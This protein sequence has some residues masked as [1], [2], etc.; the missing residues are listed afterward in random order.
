MQ[1]LHE[2]H[3]RSVHPGVPF[4]QLLWHLSLTWDPAIPATQQ[5][6]QF[7]SHNVWSIHVHCCYQVE[8][9][10]SWL[11]VGSGW[12]LMQLQL[13]AQQGIFLPQSTLSAN[14]HMVF[15]SPCVQ[16][17]TSM[18]VCMWQIPQPWQPY[19]CL[20]EQKY[21]T[22][23]VNPQRQHV[24][25]KMTGNMKTHTHSIYCIFPKMGVLSP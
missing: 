2:G 20:G 6:P 17:C 11:R 10:L 15:I 12:L 19:H 14:S 7:V 1:N 4:P 8:V 16:S 5:A 3:G 21:S 18:S 23:Q 24:A 9:Q 25:A 22:H 13:Q